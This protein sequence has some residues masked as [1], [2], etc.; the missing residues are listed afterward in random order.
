MSYYHIILEVNDH[1][2]TIEQSRDI[3]I[4]NITD[5]QPHLYA[6][7]LPYFNEQ[8]L[9]LEEEN[10]D[11]A[12]VLRLEIKQTLL[13]I[14]HLIE[15]EQKQLPSDT[16]ITIS[17]SEIFNDRDLTQDVSTVIWDLLDAVKIDQVDLE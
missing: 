10:I 3:E 7:L 6:I 12:D 16:D 5:I 8:M 9:E 17:A 4:L 11:F 2:S 15:E 14:E 1:I 13:P